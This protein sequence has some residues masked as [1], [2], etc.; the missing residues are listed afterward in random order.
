MPQ[1]ESDV[2]S[3]SCVR[4]QSLCVHQFCPPAFGFF[5]ERKSESMHA[6]ICVCMYVCM[7]ACVRVCVCE[8]ERGG[9]GRNKC[10]TLKVKQHIFTYDCAGAQR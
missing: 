3:T 7:Y 4:R 10:K 6:H 8:R 1:V 9:P 5:E 2:L